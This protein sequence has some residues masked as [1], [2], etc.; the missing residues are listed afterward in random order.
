MARKNSSGGVIVL[1]GIFV[2]IAM[3][4]KYWQLVVA[5]GSVALIIWLIAK[6]RKSSAT[7]ESGN[8]APLEIQTQAN[9]KPIPSIDTLN[10][11]RPENTGWVT[12]WKT[13]NTKSTPSVVTLNLTQPANTGRSIIQSLSYPDSSI[14][15][16][17]SDD[18]SIYGVGSQQQQSVSADSVWI[19]QGRTVE[20]DGHSIPGGLIYVGRGLKTVGGW[21][22]EPALINLSLKIDGNS[23]D[24]AGSNM[25]YWPSFSQMHPASRAAYFEWLVTGRKDPNAYIG[26]ALSGLKIA[27]VKML[28]PCTA[29]PPQFPFFKGGS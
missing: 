12:E 20:K 29:N 16:P 25:D 4:T 10:S 22:T 7:K 24:R 17:D 26:S 28:F 14:S 21:K 13:T 8:S 23:P 9:T 5:I 18:S 6:V 27:S 1:I 15:Q 19:P 3:I 2:L 11:T